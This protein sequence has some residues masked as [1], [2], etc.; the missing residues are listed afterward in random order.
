MLGYT[1]TWL[2]LCILF[3]TLEGLL[4]SLFATAAAASK[5]YIALTIIISVDNISFFQITYFVIM[6]DPLNIDSRCRSPRC[7]TRQLH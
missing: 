2:Q 6:D 7:Q 4:V 1:Y 3:T 5:Y